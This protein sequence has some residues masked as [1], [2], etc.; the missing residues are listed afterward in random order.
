M[1]NLLKK[2]VNYVKENAEF[3]PLEDEDYDEM[4]DFV[5]KDLDAG[6]LDVTGT[7]PISYYRQGN[8]YRSLD[9]I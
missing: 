5:D 2:A 8:H 3:E 1:F 6:F 7:N 9:D 4:F